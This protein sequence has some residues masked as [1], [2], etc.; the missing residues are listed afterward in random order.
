MRSPPTASPGWAR[1]LTGELGLGI[2]ALVLFSVFVLGLL[3]WY[4]P[5]GTDIKAADVLDAARAI[6]GEDVAIGFTSADSAGASL[7]VGTL[8]ELRNSV[9]SR[10]AQD[11]AWRSAS[12]GAV[13]HVQDALQTGPRSYALVRMDAGATMK[14][15]ARSLVVF[16]GEMVGITD[17]A[18][19]VALVTRGEM[20]GQVSAGSAPA[21]VRINSGT[22]SVKPAAGTAAEYTVQ[23]NE[24]ESA[25]INI[26][27]G[28]GEFIGAGG[29]TAI[30]PRQSLTVDQRGKRIS[31]VDMPKAP[32]LLL[33][34]AS[35]RIDGRGGM[36]TVDFT[37]QPVP[38]VEGYRFVIARD[39]ELYDRLADE[40][41][42]EVRFRH[43]R[44]PVGEYYWSVQ[45][46]SGWTFGVPSEVRRVSLVDD[47][48]PPQL[49]LDDVPRAID[50]RSVTIAGRTD[51]E[52]RVFVA[53]QPAVNSGGHFEHVT[54]LT[55]GANVIVVES[56][57]AVG[58]VA[59]ASVM[60]VAK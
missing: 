19:L 17:Q 21:A 14:L 30:A 29:T 41:V 52:A 22:L 46:R 44:L 50:G 27:R 39:R 43:G 45:G 60:V 40:R 23:V 57:D 55:A 49:F 4:F 34:A 2:I 48:N 56:V 38:G 58:N 32:A 6:A 31:L 53:G 26:L 47:V 9:Q 24:D 54:Q 28:R 51:P 1:L 8:A 35:A 18:R 59:Y 42:A 16:G 7:R 3:R 15:A 13:F 11:V 36:S 12:R 20:S 37:W 10:S 33:P 25:T 5:A